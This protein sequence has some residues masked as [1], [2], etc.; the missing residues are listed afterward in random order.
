[1]A[2]MEAAEAAWFGMNTEMTC[3]VWGENPRQALIAAQ[4]ELL[5]LEHKLSRFFPGSEIAAVNRGAGREA[6]AVSGETAAVLRAAREFADL[7]A[8]GFDVT[9]A[10]LLMLWRQQQRQIPAAADIQAALALV[11]ARDLQLG[12][13]GRTAKL[14]RPGQALDL[15]GIAKGYAG[16]RCLAVLREQ[17]I[18]SAFVNLGGN[19]C[20]LGLKPGGAPW[21]VGI[22][23]PRREGVLLG[24]VAVADRAVVTSG[25]YERYFI[26]AAGKRC[27]HIL[28]PATGY[29]AQRGLIS[30]TVIAGSAMTADALSTA[31]F[32]AGREKGRG[33]LAHFPGAEAVLV[34]EDMEIFITPGLQG[35]FQAVEGLKVSVL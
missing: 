28:D 5:R 29:P 25:D 17:G 22:R 10:P 21:R 30:V 14:A 24:A 32:V 26:D 6:V 9:I 15:G 19:V 1:M 4:M 20:L 2:R 18:A 16:D 34:A 33:C 7:S 13:S 12:E 31:V 11:D 3:K 35:C 27:H 8:G 23:H